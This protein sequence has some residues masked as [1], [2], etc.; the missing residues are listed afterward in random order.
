MHT[1]CRLVEASELQVHI[2]NIWIDKV[3]FQ[4]LTKT[5]LCLV[6]HQ[7]LVYHKIRIQ[8]QRTKKPQYYTEFVFDQWLYSAG[9]NKAPP[10]LHTIDR[11]FLYTRTRKIQF[12][13]HELQIYCAFRPNA[14][15]CFLHHSCFFLWRMKLHKFTKCQ[16]YKIKKAITHHVTGLD[17]NLRQVHEPFQ[18]QGHRESDSMKRHQQPPA[19]FIPPLNS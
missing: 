19:L 8:T 6:K 11:V 5:H 17:F 12:I 14:T 16:F 2:C 3:T 15:L 18:Q 1:E 7:I 4:I 10:W 9:K 13:Y